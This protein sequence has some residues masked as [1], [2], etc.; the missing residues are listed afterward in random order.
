[1]WT[2]IDSL[3]NTVDPLAASFTQPSF[4][5]AC[6]ACPHGRIIKS[7]SRQ[8]FPFGT[9][10]VIALRRNGVTGHRAGVAA[11]NGTLEIATKQLR[12]LRKPPDRETEVAAIGRFDLDNLGRL[13]IRQ[14]HHAALTITTIWNRDPVEATLLD[15]CS[16][17]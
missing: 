3:Q 10:E 7:P 9:S 5:S 4:R 12:F 14:Q 6:S 17:S 2:M 1:M 8:R 11:V 13:L 16:R 15:K